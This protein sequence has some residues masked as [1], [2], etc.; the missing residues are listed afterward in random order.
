MEDNVA[1]LSANKPVLLRAS[2]GERSEPRHEEVKTRERN[3][4]DRQFSQ[5]SVQLTGEPQAGCN[6]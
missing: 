4:V 2:G 6:T 3:H 1:E 5:V